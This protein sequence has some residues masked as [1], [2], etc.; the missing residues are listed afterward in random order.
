MR[1]L[2]SIFFIIFFIASCGGG[3][4]SGQG[5]PPIVSPNPTI[6]SFASSLQ[7]VTVGGSVILSWSSL[8]ANA[9]QATG[10]WTNS[11]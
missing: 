3:G 2:S 6:S 11:I 5:N 10:D 1:N 8:N 9:C 4:E 7:T